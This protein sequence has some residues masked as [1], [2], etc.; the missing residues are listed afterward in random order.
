[1]PS[2][3]CKGFIPL[4]K[5]ASQGTFSKA[6]LLGGHLGRHK[7]PKLKWCFP[8]AMVS[9]GVERL[10]VVFLWNSCLQ[11]TLSLIFVSMPLFIF[12]PSLYHMISFFRKKK[13]LENPVYMYGISRTTNCLDVNEISIQKVKCPQIQTL[14]FVMVAVTVIVLHLVSLGSG[15]LKKR[16]LIKTRSSHYLPLMFWKPWLSVL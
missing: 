3:P 8:T 4:W 12:A 10:T 7:V 14:E 5:T 15:D 2:V 9:D 16:K 6:S 1:M 11:V 13:N